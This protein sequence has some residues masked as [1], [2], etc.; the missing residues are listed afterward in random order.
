MCIQCNLT[1][2][3]AQ[4]YTFDLDTIYNPSTISP[5]ASGSLERL[6]ERHPQGRAAPSWA[7]GF[8]VR[9]LCQAGLPDAQSVTGSIMSV[10]GFNTQPNEGDWRLC[11]QALKPY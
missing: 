9:K 4:S 2:K 11:Q 5:S 1:L 3:W 7:R 10:N 8:T 6:L